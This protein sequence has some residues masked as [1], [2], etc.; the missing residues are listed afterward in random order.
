MMGVRLTLRWKNNMLTDRI[1]RRLKKQLSASSK[2]K[3]N[4]SQTLV[5]IRQFKNLKEACRRTVRGDHHLL[6]RSHFLRCL[7][8]ADRGGA[9]ATA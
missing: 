6:L 4:F 1:H 5:H 2:Q 9:S 7:L 3:L 8:D